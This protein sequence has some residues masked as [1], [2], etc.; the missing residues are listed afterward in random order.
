MT[1]TTAAIEFRE[2]TLR[3]GV[4]LHYADVGP[5]TGRPVLLLHG[6]S[7]SWFSFS[8]ILSSMDSQLRLIIPD[9]R[10]HGDSG[11]PD[12]GYSP[13]DLAIDA[14]ALLDALGIASTAAVGHSMGS[15]VVQRM[16]AMA[17]KRVN[18]AVLAGSA[19]SAD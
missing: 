19:A 11:R 10:G 3:S 14:L 15:F 18:R 2:V 6:Y 16:M 12:S 7:D 5:R 8:P 1:S 9:Q 17:P 4:R 13:Q